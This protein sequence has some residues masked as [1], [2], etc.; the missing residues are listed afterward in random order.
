MISDLIAAVNAL[1]VKDRDSD[2]K[3]LEAGCTIYWGVFEDT[4][5]LLPGEDNPESYL[6]AK[7]AYSKLSEDARTVLNIISDMPDELFHK[8]GRISK[9]KAEQMI[10]H[11]LRCS[12]RKVRE[13]IQELIDYAKQLEPKRKGFVR[14]S[15]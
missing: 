11:Q 7:D 14:R 1:D 6:I 2:G 15:I 8:N 5:D 10:K 13:I 4:T 3:K 9:L 12:V